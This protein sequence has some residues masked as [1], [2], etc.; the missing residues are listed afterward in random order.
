MS[1]ETITDQDGHCWPI[2]GY[3]CDSCGLP[4]HAVNVPFGTHPSCD[5]EEEQ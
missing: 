2:T 3:W 4:M 1:V 5:E